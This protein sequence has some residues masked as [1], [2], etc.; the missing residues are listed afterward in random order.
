MEAPMRGADLFINLEI[1]PAQAAAGRE[2][3]LSVPEQGTGPEK[4]LKVAVPAGIASGTRLRLPGQGCAGEPPGDLLVTIHVVAPNRR[5]TTVLWLLIA[6]AVFGVGTL[7]TNLRTPPEPMPAWQRPVSELT[8]AQQDL[9][10]QLRKG[11]RAAELSRSETKRWPAPEGIF[12]SGWALRRQ[13]TAINYLGEG[14][15]LRWLVLYLE[16]D[17][18]AEATPA[19]PED[20]EHH[21]L[22]DGTALHVTLWTQPLSEPPTELVTAFPGAEG[23]VERI[24]R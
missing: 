21:T 7:V 14:E 24:S 23:W 20:D 13:G 2:V 5:S 17:P 9:H 10:E 16:P 8:A 19:P 1:S 15:G 3:V 4:D 11:L 6:V 12:P 22:A 18:R